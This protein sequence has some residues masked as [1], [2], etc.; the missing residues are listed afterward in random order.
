MK[1]TSSEQDVFQ[2]SHYASILRSRLNAT[3]R[4][5]HDW[6]DTESSI[7]DGL[8]RLGLACPWSVQQPWHL[9]DVPFAQMGFRD[10]IRRSLLQL[11]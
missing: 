10:D 2:I 8:S 6:V 11:Q 4:A 3:R 1:C 7:G 9:V 5:W